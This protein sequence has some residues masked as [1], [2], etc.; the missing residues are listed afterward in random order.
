MKYT[1][2][3]RLAKKQGWELKRQ[4]KGSHAIYEKNGIQI[5]IPNHGAKEMPKGLERSLKKKMRL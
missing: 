3:L 1:E 5:T 4:A 2:F